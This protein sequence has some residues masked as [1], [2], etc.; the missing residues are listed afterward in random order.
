VPAGDRKVRRNGD[1]LTRLD[2]QQGAIVADTEPDR[3]SAPSLRRPSPDRAQKLNLANPRT[4]SLAS[5]LLE[6]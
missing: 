6:E 5:H 1:L 2:P 3:A 4:D